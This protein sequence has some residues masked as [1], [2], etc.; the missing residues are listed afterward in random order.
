ME[1]VG[2]PMAVEAGVDWLRRQG[3]HVELVK[4]RAPRP[5]ESW[6]NRV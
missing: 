6:P 2:R 5:W 4:D 1:L 3:L